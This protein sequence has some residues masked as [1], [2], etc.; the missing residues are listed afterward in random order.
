MV[1]HVL[2]GS[3]FGRRA[4]RF[5]LH[6]HSSKYSDKHYYA[7]LQYILLSQQNINRYSN[8]ELKQFMFLRLAHKIV[9]SIRVHSVVDAAEVLSCRY[10]VVHESSYT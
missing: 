4:N 1:L 10:S 2:K 9:R 7:M 3:T 6:K 5:E 8:Y